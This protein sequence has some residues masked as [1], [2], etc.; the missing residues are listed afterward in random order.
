MAASKQKNQMGWRNAYAARAAKRDQA[1]APLRNSGLSLQ[2]RQTRCGAPG[3]ADSCAQY[4][5]TGVGTRLHG[6]GCAHGCGAV[7]LLRAGA[8]AL[9]GST[10]GEPSPADTGWRDAAT[11]QSGAAVNAS[12]CLL[13]VVVASRSIGLWEAARPKARLA[14]RADHPSH[15]Q[16]AYRR[17]SVA[18]RSQK[19][20]TATT[21][22]A[23]I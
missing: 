21:R 7:S 23:I 10:P 5:S 9:R 14:P 19:A 18:R 13:I 11:A 22:A 3:F 15:W 8:A 12:P 4:A 6:A 17:R 16:G 2:R 20:A 1:R